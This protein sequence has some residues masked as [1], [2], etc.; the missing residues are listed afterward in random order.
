MDIAYQ[1]STSVEKGN[2]ISQSA[3]GTAAKGST[4]TLTISSG[5]GSATIPNVV[6]QTQNDAIAALQAA[7]FNYSVEQ[8]SSS[9]VTKGTVIKQSPSSGSGTKGTTVT[10]YVSTGDSR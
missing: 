7:G 3:T 6:G 5:A 1:E 2:V 8:M 4:I 10:I 9:T